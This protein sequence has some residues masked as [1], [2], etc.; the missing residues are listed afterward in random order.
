MGPVV[1]RPDKNTLLRRLPSVDEVLRSEPV[2]TLARAHPRWA[3]LEAARGEIDRLRADLL[4][5]ADPQACAITVDP[6]RIAKAVAALR[7]PSLL[8]VINATGV[9]LHTNLGRAPLHP[10]VVARVSEIARGYSNL[11]YELDARR[12]GSRHDHVAELVCELTGAEAAAGVNNNA[13]A[14]L[15]S[16]ATLAA[17]REVIVS[18]G[19]LV[20]IGGSFRVPDVMRASGATLVE[21]GTTN[22]TH[23]QDYRNAIGPQTG[24]LL[25]VHRSNFAVVGFTAEVEPAEL[26]AIGPQP[27]LPL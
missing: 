26:V 8:R 19:E 24:L 5:A 10:D 27:R 6:G 14:V 22:K 17:G 25:K 12:R 23:P 13:G 11:E 21:V 1:G 2:Q 4:A 3:V 18:R 15:I 9:V 20:E 16:L 7:R